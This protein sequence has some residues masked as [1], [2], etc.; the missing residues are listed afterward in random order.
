MKQI[1]QSYRSGELSVAEVPA[2]GLEPGHVLVLTT[3]SLV[4]V[5]TEKMVMALAKKSLLGKA[6]ARPDLVKKVMERVAR[7][8]LVSAGRAVLGRLDQ[9]I[10]LG[11]SC[12][13]RVLAVGQG[14]SELAVGDRVACAGAKVANHAEVNLVPKN[15]CVR[16]PPGL[17]DEAAAFVTV[18]AIALQGVRTAQPTLGETFAVV[19]LG[20]IGQLVAQILRA[21]GC[22]VM[23]V[24]LDA[25]KV[26]LARE[27]GADAAVLR[28]DDVLGAGA[29]L[30]AGRGVDGVLICAA[31]ASNDPIT[32]AGE[33]CRDRGRVIVVGAVGMEV[34]RRPYYD[35]ELAF[36]QSRAYGPGRYDP[37]YEEAGVDYP[38]GYVRWTEQRNMAAFLDLCAGGGLKV[39]PLISHRFAIDK[40]EDAYAV[41]ER[42]DDALGI[43]LKY[44]AAAPPSRTVTLVPRPP[45]SVGSGAVRVGFVGAG[46]F[47]SGTLV[48]AVAGAPGVRLV[49]IA[50]VRGFTARHLAER[51]RFESCSTDSAA[52]LASDDL[53]AV[54]IATRHHLHA[55][56]AVAALGAGKHVFVEKPL[57]LDREG[58]DRVLEAQRSSGTILAVGYNRRFAPLARELQALLAARRSPLVM[59][60]RVNAGQVPADSWIQDPA[61]GGG[62]ILGEVCHFVDLCAFLAGARPVSVY[63][64][65]V[66]PRG[67]ARSD[68]NVTLS[69][70]FGDGSLATIAFVATG[71][72]SAGKERLEVLGDGTQAVLEDFRT[73]SFRTGGREQ[74]VKKLGQ[75]KGHVAGVTAF[76]E[77]IRKGAPPPI[78]VD[79][80][81]AVSLATLAAIDSLATGEPV[82]VA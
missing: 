60:Y 61:V 72:T 68:D 9:P 66:D 20:L 30:T 35:K 55:D 63:A 79:D 62:R 74:R 32:L 12:A 65:A 40:A 80:L 25:R 71:D 4:S 59:H 33:L 57:A 67:V 44:P 22:R 69:L 49:A 45:R 73:L 52:L 53:D 29:A 50:S 81:A 70:K 24:D 48:P 64:Q 28:T 75:D 37:S 27:L 18:G 17:D 7:D 26:Q 58:L 6:R 10:P 51:H 78:P 34:P 31:T 46:S 3:A 15:L 38:L 16:V 42:G 1:L 13:G 82:A 76:L 56:Q 2:P 47:A 43:V 14:V 36:L 23:G 5:G 19:G 54:F 39:L 21:N 77:A 8:G 11:Y 41:I